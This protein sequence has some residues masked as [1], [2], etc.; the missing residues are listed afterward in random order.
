MVSALTTALSRQASP[1]W[2]QHPV[3]HLAR[4]AGQLENLEVDAGITYLDNE[5]VGRVARCRSILNPTVC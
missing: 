2:L 4:P 1:A 5:T 3:A